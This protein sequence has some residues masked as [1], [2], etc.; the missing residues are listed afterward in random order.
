MMMSR[1]ER[2]LGILCVVLAV[3]SWHTLW[4]LGV[5]VV[6]MAVHMFHI[7]MGLSCVPGVSA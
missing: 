6:Q 5:Q 1:R 7:V 2:M 4:M 3:V